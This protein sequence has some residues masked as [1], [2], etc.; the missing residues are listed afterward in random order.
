MNIDIWEVIDA[1]AR[2][3]SVTCVLSGAR[4]GGH[5]AYPLT[6]T[7]FPG[8]RANLILRRASSTRRRSQHRDALPRRRRGVEFPERSQEKHEGLENPSFGR[9]LQK[10]WTTCVSRRR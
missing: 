4:T 5:H 3:L 8:K 2:S 9:G 6:P 1:A 10:M 7:T